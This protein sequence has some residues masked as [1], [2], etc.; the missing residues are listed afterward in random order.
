MGARTLELSQ[1]MMRCNDANSRGR[2]SKNNSYEGVIFLETY[3]RTSQFCQHTVHIPTCQNLRKAPVSTECKPFTRG[4][5]NTEAE[6]R[7]H[8]SD[9]I[10]MKTLEQYVVLYKRCAN[11]PTPLPHVPT[12][13]IETRRVCKT[14]A[15]EATRPPYMPTCCSV[16]A[17]TTRPKMAIMP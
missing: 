3:T 4:Y 5:S 7:P 16:H 10:K 13:T 17:H 2:W 15:N 6:A 14:T 1:K 12:S 9:K 11:R 8:K